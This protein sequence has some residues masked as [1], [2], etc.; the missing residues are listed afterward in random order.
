MLNLDHLVIAGETLAD[1]QYYVEQTL[2]VKMQP[3]GQHAVFAT[4]NALLHLDDG[5]YLEAIAKE[6]GAVPERSPCW[7][8]LDHF[9]GGPR[10]SN[11]ACR[12]DQ[13]QQAANRW[14]EAGSPIELAR[15]DLQW[16]MFVP[17]TGKLPY[18]NLFP[19]LLSWQGAHPT[20]RLS[21]KGCSLRRFVV[22]HPQA[23]DLRS[24]LALED[25]R[26]VF[27]AGPPGLRA[28]IETPHGLRVL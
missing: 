24:S 7:Y 17:E 9:S 23:M 3:G 14:P 12:T 6:P 13:P 20:E 21:P 8:A 18:D 27:E 11:W 26:L 28:E 1:A 15:G 25:S 5:I 19:A 16:Q 2:G 4:H 10:L 22:S